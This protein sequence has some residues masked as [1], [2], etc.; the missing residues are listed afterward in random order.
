MQRADIFKK[1]MFEIN[2]EIPEIGQLKSHVKVCFN[3]P[4]EIITMIEKSKLKKLSEAK[5]EEFKNSFF[6]DKDLVKIMKANDPFYIDDGRKIGSINIVSKDA[7]CKYIN[8][9]LGT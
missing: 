6:K 4:N 8:W 3:L 5:K 1:Y 7:R 9:K 2:I